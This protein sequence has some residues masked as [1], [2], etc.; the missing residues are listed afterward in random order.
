MNPKIIFCLVLVLGLIS[1][2]KLSKIQE[3]AEN[4]YNGCSGSDCIIYDIST[5][6][7]CT[8]KTAGP[9]YNLGWVKGLSVQ[10][11]IPLAGGTVHAYRLQWFSGAWTNWF[12]VGVNDIDYKK[13]ADQTMR[14]MWAYFYDNTHEFILCS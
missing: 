2:K 3:S 7:V 12:V 14:R 4:T 9:T 5:Q 10:D 11:V 1:S 8:A 13:N 6:D